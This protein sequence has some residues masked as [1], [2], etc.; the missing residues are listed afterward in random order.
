[1]SLKRRQK[2]S[3]SIDDEDFTIMQST[4][5]GAPFVNST[6]N[7]DVEMNTRYLTGW[8][9]PG[10][11]RRVKAGELIPMTPFHQT[12][13]VGSVE[14]SMDLTYQA[15]ATTNRYWTTG[16]GYVFDP[17]WQITS[18]ELH[19]YVTPD[20][21]KAYVQEAAAMIYSEG[22][23]AL[24]ALAELADVKRMFMK[25][26]RTLTS[27]R[28]LKKALDTPSTWLEARYGWRPLIYDIRELNEAIKNFD[29]RRSRY[30]K[31]K[32]GDTSSTVETE[33]E[34]VWGY[35]THVLTI[36][37]EITIGLRGSVVA[38]IT[39]PKVQINPLITGWELVPF[40]FVIDWFLQVGKSIAAMSFLLMQSN[41]TAAQG[42]NVTINRTTS[43]ELTETRTG[44]QS[45][46][47][48]QSSNFVATASKRVPTSVP[49]FPRIKLNLNAFKIADLVA[50]II[51]RIR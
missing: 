44:Y 2:Q 19:E 45:G 21:A 28:G 7:N 20:D 11:H 50:L 34:T 35:V 47:C 9:T 32:G 41:Y 29:E 42:I 22:Y 37:D 27:K 8:D 40:S 36:S 14:A 3:V 18:E 33:S 31:R 46:Q 38:D 15:G 24:T 5:G 39:V 13:Y 43:L 51:Q 10:Y 49:L 30:S 12:S 17:A 1:M 4:N 23:D 16:N 6:G 48:T 25:L 26:G